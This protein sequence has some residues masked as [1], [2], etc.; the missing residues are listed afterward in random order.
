CGDVE[1]CSWLPTPGR[2]PLRGGPPRLQVRLDRP[3]GFLTENAFER[4]HIDAPFAGAP[5]T[6]RFDEVGLEFLDAARLRIALHVEALCIELA[7]IRRDAS[8]DGL[9][10]VATGTVLVKSG[11]PHPDGF[12]LSASVAVGVVLEPVRAELRQCMRIDRLWRHV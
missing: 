8:R 10:S 6:D 5:A 2:R 7:Q 9:E 4:R 3:E 12:L 11:R 1:T